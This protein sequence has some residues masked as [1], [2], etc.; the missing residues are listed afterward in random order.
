[1]NSFRFIYIISTEITTDW[2]HALYGQNSFQFACSVCTE[3]TN[4]SAIPCEQ[5]HAHLYCLHWN[6]RRSATRY[7][8][9]TGWSILSPLKRQTASSWSVLF[10]LNQHMIN[11]TMW[12]L[13]W[14]MKQLVCL[15]VTH[16]CLTEITNDQTLWTLSTQKNS[17][18]H[19][20]DMVS[21]TLWTLCW[22]FK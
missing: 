13:C 7:E 3:M 10:P 2:Q 19:W 21:S 1:M 15:L 14:S 4:W 20:N 18:L 16:Y 22:S 8:H 9:S 17:S 11:N 5:L 12:T 6:D